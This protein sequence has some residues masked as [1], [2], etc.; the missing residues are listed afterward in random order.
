MTHDAY[1][2]RGGSQRREQTDETSGHRE[3]TPE[4]TSPPLPTSYIIRDPYESDVSTNT[5]CGVFD[6]MLVNA[7]LTPEIDE[8][9][10]P[11]Q[12]S[13]AFRSQSGALI[14]LTR[15]LCYD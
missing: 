10:E 6:F 5:L 4:T 13:W 14:R 7:R 3:P 11:G 12:R 9:P 8:E 1:I 2:A 15:Y